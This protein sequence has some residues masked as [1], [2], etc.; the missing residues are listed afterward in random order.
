MYA[1]ICEYQNTTVERTHHTNTKLDARTNTSRSLYLGAAAFDAIVMRFI[2]P[3][4]MRFDH[5]RC[6]NL[7]S[8]FPPIFLGYYSSVYKRD[9]RI[10]KY[11]G[12]ILFLYGAGHA[13]G[14][15]GSQSAH[16]G[17]PTHRPPLPLPPRRY[18]LYSFLLEA[19][20][21]TGL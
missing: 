8:M 20:S 10:S 21:A 11:I 1:N 14:I 2:V 19:E 7:K 12:K 5:Y 9:A 6:F 17:S 18:P 13:P 3:I 15:W 4:K 16:E